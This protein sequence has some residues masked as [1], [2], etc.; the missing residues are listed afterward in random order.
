[1]KGILI[2]ASLL[3]LTLTAGAQS[4]F[5]SDTKYR[6]GMENLFNQRIKT[7]GKKFYNTQKEKLTLQIIQHRSL[8]TTCAFRSRL[9]MKWRGARMYLNYCF[10]TLCCQ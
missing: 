4:G 6:A 9:V 7:V 1:M 5:I 3:A 10:V 2:S 8:P